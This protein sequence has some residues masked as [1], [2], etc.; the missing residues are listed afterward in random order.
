MLSTS[1]LC[2]WFQ[3][4]KLSIQ[5]SVAQILGEI[6]S[7]VK[8]RLSQ[9]ADLG[10]ED[11]L[12]TECWGKKGRMTSVLGTPCHF[13]AQSLRAFGWEPLPEWS[14][15]SLGDAVIVVILPVSKT[16]HMVWAATS[17]VPRTTWKR[18]TVVPGPGRSVS[19]WTCWPLQNQDDSVFQSQPNHS[20][21]KWANWRLLEEE[22]SLLQRH[23]FLLPCYGHDVILTDLFG[24][25]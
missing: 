6:S 4:A 2:L 20:S 8:P 3:M 10:A 13:K 16:K 22:F 9:V 17:A 23:L 15:G 21:M 19:H 12:L 7:N 11:F 18:P 5:Q 25:I 14:C 1:F 24:N